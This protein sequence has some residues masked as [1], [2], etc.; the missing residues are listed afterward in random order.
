MIVE[1]LVVLVL[2]ATVVLMVNVFLKLL[3]PVLLEEELAVVTASLALMVHHQDLVILVRN[4][5]RVPVAV[6]LVQ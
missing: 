2:Q 3:I 4:V 1:A 6:P 5:V